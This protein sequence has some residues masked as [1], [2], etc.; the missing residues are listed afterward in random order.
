M[1][2][3]AMV[4]RRKYPRTDTSFPVE[5]DVLQAKNYFYT[6]SKDL[7][8][9]GV[10]IISNKFLPKDSPLKVNINLINKVLS[11]KAKVAWCNNARV[12]ERYIAGLEFVGIGNL[13]QQKIS[14][15]LGMI[16]TLAP[17]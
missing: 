12:S 13:D 16:N 5:C 15:F 11:V 4:E 7:S 14:R 9:G 3:V 10:K 1:K 6:V 8:L 17:V 2:P